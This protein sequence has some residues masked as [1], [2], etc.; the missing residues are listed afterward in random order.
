[1][2]ETTGVTTEFVLEQDLYHATG[3][4]V[5]PSGSSSFVDV[6][7]LTQGQYSMRMDPR[8]ARKSTSSAAQAPTANVR[9]SSYDAAGDASKGCCGMSGL[10]LLLPIPLVWIRKRLFESRRW[11]N[12]NV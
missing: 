4:A 2:N 3:P 9:I 1:V 6:D 12:S 5:L 8:W 10:I 7:G 11:R